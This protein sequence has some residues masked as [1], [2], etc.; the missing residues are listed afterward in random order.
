[1]DEFEKRAQDAED[2]LAA[3]EAKMVT[4]SAQTTARKPDDDEKHSYRIVILQMAL[5]RYEKQVLELQK[6]LQSRDYQIKMLRDGLE[7]K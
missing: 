7:R 3:L 4:C 6:T 2:R 5:D 1:M